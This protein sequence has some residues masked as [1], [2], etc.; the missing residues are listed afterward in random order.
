MEISDLLPKIVEILEVD[1]K[2]E[3]FCQAN[4][5][6]SPKI[7]L[8]FDEDN[9]PEPEDYPVIVI[10][11]VNRAERGDSKGFITYMVLIGVAVVNKERDV[12]GKHVV[13]KGLGQ[14]EKFRELV[15]S[16]FFGKVGH[17]VNV[18]SQT[19]TDVIYPIFAATTEIEIQFVQ[20]SRSPVK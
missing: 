17:K 4:F 14:S 6:K 10:P 1:A 13:Y 11:A 12:S 19:T 16:A 2:I 15:E 9:P 8:G 3:A 18:A 5:S 7:F 20:T